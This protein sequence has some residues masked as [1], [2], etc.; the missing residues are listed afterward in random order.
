M[1][2]ARTTANE[3]A[4]LPVEALSTIARCCGGVLHT[5]FMALTPP[6]PHLTKSQ[7]ALHHVTGVRE[8]TFSAWGYIF[9]QKSLKRLKQRHPLKKEYTT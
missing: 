1:T 6:P 5:P 7:I 8:P 3:F 4:E 9:Y 2:F